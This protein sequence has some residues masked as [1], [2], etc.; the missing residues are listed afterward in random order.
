M[1][2]RVAIVGGGVAGIAAALRLTDEG[3]HVTLLE[4]SNRLGGRAG[5]FEDT[6]LDEAIDNC[7]HVALGC[8]TAYLGLLDRLGVSDH[9]AWTSAFHYIEPDG[10]RSTLPIPAW[11]APLHGLPLLA[12][13][14]F[15]G[16]PDRLA[17]A[18]AMA[19][20]V[21]TDASRWAGRSF[22]DW[23]GQRRQPERAVRRFWTPIVVSACNAR[24]EACDAPAAIKVFR[25]GFLAS[26]RDARMGVP[27]VPLA[28]LY[29]RTGEI[30]REQGGELRLSAH[31]TGVE[32]DGVTLRSGEVLDAEAVVLA[33]PFNA[34]TDLLEASS[35]DAGTLPERL[36][37]LRHSP[38]VAVHLEY[39]QP[40]SDLPHAV[41]L[42]SEFDWL[43]FKQGGRRVH[44][45]ASAADALVE[46]PGE[47]LVGSVVRDI[48]ERFR[49]DAEPTWAR[50][51]KERRA[52]FLVEP[53]V[54]RL[55][56]RVD[57]FA[58]GFWVAGDYTASGWPATMEGAARSGVSAAESVIDHLHA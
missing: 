55:R 52:T 13:A 27:T 16:V 32:S 15:L 44:A 58:P 48:R 53:G 12:K 23:L 42:E 26:H 4:R 50:A 3:I 21:R 6:T 17:I 20:L 40:V 2:R 18:R 30:L 45:V 46:R 19:S 10:G 47:E 39:A 34:T 38:I 29:E 24:P 43:F 5:S 49:V 9:I 51:I 33:T 8:C 37:G 54:E 56:P 31:V 41:L 11:P 14:R 57:E 1:T 36:R 25:D 35:I 22:A 7:Q 28:S